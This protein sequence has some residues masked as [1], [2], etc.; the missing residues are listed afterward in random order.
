MI[1]SGILKEHRSLFTHLT[2]KSYLRR[3]HERHSGRFEAVAQGGPFVP[4][5]DHAEVR[6]GHGVAVDRVG[7]VVSCSLGQVNAQLVSEQIEVD[8]PWGAASLAASK[9]FPVEGA[10]ISEIGD[11]DGQVKW[12]EWIQLSSTPNVM[13]LSDVSIP[14]GSGLVPNQVSM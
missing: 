12:G 1:A 13:Q 9:D 8:P 5:E 2:L 6:H 11:G 3:D 7:V 10:S 14:L 4:G